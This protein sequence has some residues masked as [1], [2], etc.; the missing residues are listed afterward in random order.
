MRREAARASG[1]LEIREAVGDLGS[2]MD[3]ADA[4]VRRAAIAALGKIGG[5]D[6]RQLLQKASQSADAEIAVAAQAA[7]DEY[8]F[9]FGDL[10]FSVGPFDD[11]IDGRADGRA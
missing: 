3:D 1:E 9:L 6:A 4:G 7:L 8:D 11:L 10:K 2:L 5:D